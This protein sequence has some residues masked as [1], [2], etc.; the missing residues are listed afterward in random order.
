MKT[1]SSFE[2]QLFDEMIKDVERLRATNPKGHIL[3]F[4]AVIEFYTCSEV[5]HKYSS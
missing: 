1:E 3:M 2:E 5:Y 4:Q